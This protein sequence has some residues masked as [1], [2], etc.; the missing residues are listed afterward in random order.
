MALVPFCFFAVDATLFIAWNRFY[1]L[2]INERIVRFG[3]FHRIFT[4]FFNQMSKDFLP[5]SRLC[6]TVEK[7]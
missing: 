6:S 2:R 4:S 7:L 5:Q 3:T 1:A